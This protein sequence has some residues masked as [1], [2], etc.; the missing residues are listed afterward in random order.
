MLRSGKIMFRV[1]NYHIHR[2]IFF[3]LDWMHKGARERFNKTWALE[4]YENVFYLIDE[5]PFAILYLYG[6]TGGPNAP[7]NV[8]LEL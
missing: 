3:C 4:F 5:E 2:P 6:N 1:N 7:L 8:L